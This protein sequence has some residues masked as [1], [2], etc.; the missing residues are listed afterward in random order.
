MK[1]ILMKLLVDHITALSNKPN[2]TNNSKGKKKLPLYEIYWKKKQIINAYIDHNANLISK[3][4]S[5]LP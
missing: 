1:I 3:N 4:T 2:L 5:I